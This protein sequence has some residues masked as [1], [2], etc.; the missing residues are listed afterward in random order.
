MIP[1][2]WFQTVIRRSPAL[3]CPCGLVWFPSN[4][5][6]RSSCTRFDVME[7]RDREGS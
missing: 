3:K 4:R 6:P 5:Q 1:H 7:G 2:M